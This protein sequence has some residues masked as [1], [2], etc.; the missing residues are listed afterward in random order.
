MSSESLRMMMVNAYLLDNSQG[1][2]I[3]LHSNPTDE[4]L[5]IYGTRQVLATVLS[6]RL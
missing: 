6:V 4:V 2:G 3:G 5:L 1:N